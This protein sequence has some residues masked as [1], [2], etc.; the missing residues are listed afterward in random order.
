M[1]SMAVLTEEAEAQLLA[2]AAA[3]AAANPLPPFRPIAVRGGTPRAVWVRV[4]ALEVDSSALS[5]VG[6]FNMHLH[7]LQVQARR[8]AAPP[9]P[10]L[11][12]R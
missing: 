8:P 3:A 11:S 10:R 4:A 1:R 9:S 5:Y 6:G 7:E 2:E 12:A